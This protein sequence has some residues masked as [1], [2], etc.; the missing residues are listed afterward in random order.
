LKVIPDVTREILHR[1]LS[2]NTDI[3]K[4]DALYT[5][6]LRSYRGFAPNHE[7]VVHSIGEW[8]RGDVHTNSVEN[9]WSLLKRAIIG[10]YHRISHKHL[11]AYLDELEF[12]FGNRDNPKL[13][14][15]TIA[16]LIKA[17]TLPFKKLIAG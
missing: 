6:E 13:F 16:N 12:R 17:E 15:D 9:V 5:D 8:V 4:L 11:D 14:R 2:E 10:A 3:A 1:F 7:T